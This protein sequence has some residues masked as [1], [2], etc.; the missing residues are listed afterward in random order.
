VLRERCRA[1]SVLGLGGIGKSALVTS[2][3][4]QWAMH[5][6]VVL[7]RSLRDACVGYFR[8]PFVHPAYKRSTNNILP[9]H[10]G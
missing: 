3:M 5:F 6:Q 4:R 2:A 7:F 8:H 9:I 10:E 1:V